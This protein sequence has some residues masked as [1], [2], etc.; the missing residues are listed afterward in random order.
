V[1][2][3]EQGGGKVSG[4]IL[5]IPSIE[6]LS[7]SF[8]SNIRAEIHGNTATGGDYLRHLGCR[9]ISIYDAHTAIQRDDNPMDSSK[10]MV[11]EQISYVRLFATYEERERIACVALPPNVAPVPSSSSTDEP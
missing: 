9:S 11:L 2:L 5:G 7:R 6:E 3:D 1:G 4:Y 10:R 8:T